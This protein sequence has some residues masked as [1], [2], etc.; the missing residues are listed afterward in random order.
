MNETNLPK[1][2]V[3]A[4]LT[5][6]VENAYDDTLKQPL[7]SSS[8]AITTLVDFFHNTVLYP[9][10]QYNLYAKDKL[11]NYANELENRAKAIPSE[12][13]VNSRVNILGP[14]ID[15]LKYNLDEEYIKE[16]FTNILVSDMD[17]SKRSRVLPSYIEIVKQ[18]SKEDVEFL[19]LL[20]KYNHFA[21]I[22]IVLK[23]INE[24][25]LKYLDK[26]IMY[27]YIKNSNVPQFNIKQ[28]DPLII[29]NLTYLNLIETDY[30]TYY[31]KKEDEY[32]NLFNIAKKAYFNID[33]STYTID[34]EKGLVE[35]TKF[36]KN[37][38]DICLS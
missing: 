7:Q 15:G 17:K 9:M 25:G 26:F 22:G 14:T 33:T 10:Q 38:I 35:F 28:L 6:T 3:K 37:F 8:N 18:L 34:Y 1:L 11:Q 19:L 30:E 31:P 2:E 29:D 13:L 5:K 27:D 12:N 16:M 21:S 4:D 20:K 24:K 23:R 32:E 36:G